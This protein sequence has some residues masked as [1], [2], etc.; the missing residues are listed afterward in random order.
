MSLDNLVDENEDLKN[1]IV[2]LEHEIAY[3]REREA[4]Y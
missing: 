1:K 4:E 3:Y 2:R